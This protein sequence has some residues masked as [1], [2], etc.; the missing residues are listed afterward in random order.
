MILY[1]FATAISDTSE[2]SV[3]STV[4]AKSRGVSLIHASQTGLREKLSPSKAYLK[5]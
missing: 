3:D 1:R 2:K 4:I 5:I